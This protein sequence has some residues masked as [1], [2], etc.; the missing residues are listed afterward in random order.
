MDW[1]KIFSERVAATNDGDVVKILKLSEQPEIISLAGGLPDPSVF[2]MDEFKKISDEV[3]EQQGRT[4]LGYG[5]IAGIASFRDALALET[6]KMGR[7]TKSEEIIVTT[8]GLAAIDLITKVLVE[9]GDVVIV[10]EPTFAAALHV[11]RSYDAELV[12]VPLDDKGMDPVLLEGKL[13]ELK[14]ANKKVK[15]IYVIPSFQN[16]AGVTIPEDRRRKITTTARQYGVPILEDTAYR[17]IRFE[18]TAPPMMATLDPENVMLVNTLSKTLNPGMRLGWVA[19]PQ[20]LT[21]ALILAKQGQDQCSSTISQFMATKMLNG[22]MMDRQ[23]D[24]AIKVYHKKRDVMLSALEKYMP[25][26]VS[27]TKPEGGFFIWLT[28]PERIDATAALDEVVQNEG[29]AYVPG[30]AFH[31]AREAKNQLRLCYSYVSEQKI[32]EAI[33]KL[34]RYFDTSIKSNH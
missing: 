23:T 8:G 1:A 29:V 7:P 14:S 9:P 27:W 18:G 2:M 19:A 30:S 34:A 4:A 20:E 6:T 12:G 25:D 15:L 22:G 24:R 3:I 5:A 26:G 17:K 32:E 11:F 31:H 21:N 33:E 28:L 13:R 16:P 10:G